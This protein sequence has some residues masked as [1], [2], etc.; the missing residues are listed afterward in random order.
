MLIKLVC[1]NLNRHDTLQQPVPAYKPASLANEKLQPKGYISVH[2]QFNNVCTFYEM[3]V[4]MSW[5][6]GQGIGLAIV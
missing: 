2:T 4:G 6:N 5:P 1:L 3:Y